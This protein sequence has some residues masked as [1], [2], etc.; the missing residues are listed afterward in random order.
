VP[1]YQEA[2]NERGEF[3]H[4]KK[5][6]MEAQEK[7]IKERDS[8]LAELTKLR[9]QKDIVDSELADARLALSS[10]TIPEVVELAKMQNEVTQVR[11]EN[12]RLQ[13]RIE[14]MQ[15]DLE[16]VRNEYQNNSTAAANS[17]SELRELQVE[18]ERLRGKADA[19]IVQI[20]EIQS[21]NDEAAYVK[22]IREL[23][24]K[25][26]ELERQLETKSEELKALMNGRRATR[27]TSVPRS[28][29][30]GTQGTMSPGPR[31]GMQSVMGV[32]SNANGSRGNSPAPGEQV[33]RASGFP[34]EALFQG[35]QRNW[36]HHLQQ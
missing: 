24:I 6:A 7:A 34:G 9:E 33:L 17:A 14:N 16:Y 26:E 5:Q 29:R 8:K 31:R 25:N 10:A 28:P 20:H 2:L 36:G 12:E 27:G 1:K 21:R 22:R 4:I 30:M 18:T 3:E 35:P 23:K 15:H 13:K 11:S 19:N 32:I